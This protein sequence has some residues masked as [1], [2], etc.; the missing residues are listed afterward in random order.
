MVVIDNFSKFGRTSFLKIAQ[1]ITNSLE[2]VLKFSKRKPKL[3]EADDGSKSVNRFL[4]N[5]SI[6][7]NTGRLSK[8]TSLGIASGQRFNCSIRDLLR[9]SVF[10]KGDA[11][12]IDVLPLITEQIFKKI[13]SSTKLA[14]IQVFMKKNKAYVPRNVLDKTKKKTKTNR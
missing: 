2:N 12:W 13:H 7:N 6:Q 9:R 10:G 3:I 8:N 11:N 1:T 5:P 14:P 4:T